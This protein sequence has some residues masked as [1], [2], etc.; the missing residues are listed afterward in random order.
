MKLEPTQPNEF[1]KSAVKYCA[2]H[3]S[4]DLFLSCIIIHLFIFSTALHIVNNKI[5]SLSQLSHAEVNYGSNP[6]FICNF[7]RPG[8]LCTLYTVKCYYMT[9]KQHPF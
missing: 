4:V 5:V 9:T 7:Y 1:A 3:D 2:F 6:I 8:F